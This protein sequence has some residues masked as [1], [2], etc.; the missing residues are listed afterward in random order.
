MPGGSDIASKIVTAATA[1]AT[2]A[3]S[4]INKA[5]PEIKLGSAYGC[6]KMAD[7]ETCLHYPL[8]LY[9]AIFGVICL[10]LASIGFLEKEKQGA[11]RKRTLYLTVSFILRALGCAFYS[12]CLVFAV[13]SYYGVAK[14]LQSQ[15]GGDIDRGLAYGASIANFG[16]SLAL[17]VY[18]VV[19]HARTPGM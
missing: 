1:K 9:S 16:A 8:F 2:E 10:C 7:Q 6:W 3:V 4:V 11:S 17:I 15:F 12:I 14:P 19:R 5:L 13:G 18:D